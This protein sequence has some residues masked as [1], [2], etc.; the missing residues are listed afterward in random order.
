MLQRHHVDAH[1]F[2]Q[3]HLQDTQMQVDNNT[4][5]KYVQFHAAK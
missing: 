3:I 2:M 4:K 5:Y 1:I